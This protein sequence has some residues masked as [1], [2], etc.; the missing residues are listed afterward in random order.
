MDLR[1][2]NYDGS[3]IEDLEEKSKTDELYLAYILERE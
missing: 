3:Y 2:E 1:L